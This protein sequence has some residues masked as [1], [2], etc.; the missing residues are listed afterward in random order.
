M[1]SFV[2]RQTPES[3]ALAAA[4]PQVLHGSAQIPLLLRWLL[5]SARLGR[6]QRPSS[7]I[8]DRSTAADGLPVT[9]RQTDAFPRLH[10]ICGG[11]VPAT[12]FQTTCKPRAPAC[13]PLP[14]AAYALRT[15][16]TLTATTGPHPEQ[17][18]QRDSNG[19]AVP[20]FQALALS[21]GTRRMSAW[22]FHCFCPHHKMSTAICILH[23][24]RNERCDGNHSPIHPFTLSPV[25]ICIHRGHTRTPCPHVQADHPSASIFSSSDI[26]HPPKASGETMKDIMILLIHWP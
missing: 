20:P 24:Q 19:D 2:R 15:P 26:P 13:A 6:C 7:S 25:L 9:R 16:M 14:C 22:L 1:R 18:V 12:V 4:Y 5:I 8:V 17:Q 23:L 3:V 10:C 21:Q 11:V